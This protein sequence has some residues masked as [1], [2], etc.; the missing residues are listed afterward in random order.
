[1]KHLKQQKVNLRNVMIK[2]AELLFNWVNEK[3][4]R[5]NSIKT[6]FIEWGDHIKWLKNK[7][8]KKNAFMFIAEIK[9]IPIGQIRF[10]KNYS[11][12]IIDYS[13]DRD[14]RGQGIGEKILIEGINIIKSTDDYPITFLAKVKSQNIASKIWR[15]RR[16]W[17]SAKYR[18]L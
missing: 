5:E 13:V 10:E 4:V 11:N 1:M 7:L 14:Y 12:Y 6:T 9:N 15:S 17:V 3:E 8:K 18:F 2:D 16:S